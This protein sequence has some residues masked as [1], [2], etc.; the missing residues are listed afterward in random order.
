MASV[1][2]RYLS[3]GGE[4]LRGIRQQKVYVRELAERDNGPTMLSE[5]RFVGALCKAGSL[6]VN[7]WLSQQFTNYGIELLGALGARRLDY[8]PSLRSALCA[9][10]RSQGSAAD[11]STRVS[12]LVG[13]Q[14]CGTLTLLAMLFRWA[15]VLPDGRNLVA[16]K[17][18]ADLTK[19]LGCEW[20]NAS[21]RPC[22]RPVRVLVLRC[23][24]CWCP[25]ND[26][27]DSEH[28]VL[29]RQLVKLC[30]GFFVDS[31]ADLFW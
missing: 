5:L 11:E 23:S 12:F 9:A 6:C 29:Y 24:L 25:R 15:Q 10:A 13:E 4:A 27:R 19:V 28:P 17:A 14:R 21:L 22:A 30:A 31:A 18:R 3:R 16:R 20:R 7:K 8:R 1:R 26:V 2:P